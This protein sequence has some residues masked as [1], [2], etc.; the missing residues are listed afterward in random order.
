MIISTI[1]ALIN[2]YFIISFLVNLC[3]FSS[4]TDDSVH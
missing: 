2:D 4:E 1:R 3:D